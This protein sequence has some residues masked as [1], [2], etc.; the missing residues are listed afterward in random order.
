MHKVMP[1]ILRKNGFDVDLY[2][3]TEEIKKS[4]LSAKEYKKR[5]EQEKE[6][7][8]KRLDNLAKEY[9]DLADKY[10]KL[11]DDKAELDCKNREKALEV[12]NQQE[13]TR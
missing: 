4:G 11:I 7:L 2:E 6:E 3:E 13:R 5:M 9:N 12:I 1:F 8:N 10:N